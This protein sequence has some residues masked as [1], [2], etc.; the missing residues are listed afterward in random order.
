MSG[1]SMSPGMPTTTLGRPNNCSWICAVFRAA[2][3]PETLSTNH[4]L[5]ALQA[6]EERPWSEW[7]RGK[8]ISARGLAHV[9]KPF[10]VQPATIHP[11]HSWRGQG[12][13][14]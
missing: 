10:K 12:V 8:P 14:P 9:L 11:L 1:G 13:S 6:L 2:G 4:L 7:R 5:G 3:D